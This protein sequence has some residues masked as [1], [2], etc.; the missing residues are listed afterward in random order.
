MAAWPSR[1]IPS[2]MMIGALE[3]ATR[4]FGLAIRAGTLPPAAARDRDRAPVSR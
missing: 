4:T 3:P 2:S 1:L